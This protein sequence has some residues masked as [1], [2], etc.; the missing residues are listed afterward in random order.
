MKARSTSFI[1]LELMMQV[2][3]MNENEGLYMELIDNLSTNIGFTELTDIIYIEVS[4][5]Y[6]RS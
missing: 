2:M 5:N 1:L 4:I 3:G 6:S